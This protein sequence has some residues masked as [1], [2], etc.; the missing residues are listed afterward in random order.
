[1]MML[2]FVSSEIQYT[3]I[4][5]TD[6]PEVEETAHIEGD[7]LQLY[8]G[9]DFFFE[10]MYIRVNPSMADL[11]LG[12]NWRTQDHIFGSGIQGTHY[13]LY[14]TFDTNTP[15]INTLTEFLEQ[16]IGTREERLKVL[17]RKT[18]K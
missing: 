10:K 15:A 1:M 18:Q 11:M 16:K 3:F 5:D 4:Q 2:Y 14:D 9:P 7:G 17:L 6:Y 8:I 12:Y 13:N